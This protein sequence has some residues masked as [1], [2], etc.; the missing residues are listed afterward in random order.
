ME[1]IELKGLLEQ[2]AM[3]AVRPDDAAPVS[4]GLR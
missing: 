4:I 1:R 3:G 2:V